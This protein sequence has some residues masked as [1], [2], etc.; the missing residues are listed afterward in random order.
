MEALTS[1]GSEL[2]SQSARKARYKMK[3]IMKIKRGKEVA[4]GGLPF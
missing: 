4:E 1:E 2:L 3:K